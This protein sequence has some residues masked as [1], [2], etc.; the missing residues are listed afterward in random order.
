MNRYSD[1]AQDRF[2][3]HVLQTLIVLGGGETVE[4]E[5]SLPTCLHKHTFNV[6]NTGFRQQR[7][8]NIAAGPMNMGQ[9]SGSTSEGQ[10]PTMT[11]CIVSLTKV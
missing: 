7:R 6:A 3:S 2:A 1:I 8:G 4:R 10:L 9:D 11:E 5:V